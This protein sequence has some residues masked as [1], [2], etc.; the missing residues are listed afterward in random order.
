MRKIKTQVLESDQY[1]RTLIDNFPFMVWLKDVDSRLLAA[2]A[3][4][5]NMVGVSSSEQLTV[6][7]DFDFFPA[8][9][10]Q[11]YVDGDKAAM[12]SATPLGVIVPIKNAEGNYRWIESYKSALVVDGKVVGSLGYARDITEK[13][14]KDNE[15]QSLVEN[16][17]NTVSRFNS[18][19]QR[20]FLNSK[21]SQFYE[22]DSH[23]LL[24]TTPT[25]FPGG[26]SAVMLEEKIREVF[27]NGANQNVVFELTT[28]MVGKRLRI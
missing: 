16:S 25:E 11:Q 4:Y 1:L 10:A 19:C 3:A 21:N 13:V 20:V 5:A 28:K 9:L 2:N 26:D 6:K 12:L 27:Q 15:Y 8:D 23:L 17:P 22:V 7:T 14:Q 24:G 18:D